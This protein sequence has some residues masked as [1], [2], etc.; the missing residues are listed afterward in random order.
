MENTAVHRNKHIKKD[1][2]SKLFEAGAIVIILLIAVFSIIPFL[3]ILSGSFSKESEIIVKG[4]SLLPQGFTLDSYKMVFNLGNRISQAYFITIVTTVAGTALGLLTT[5]M[6]GYVLSR[7]DFKHRNKAAFFIYFTTL[8]S[9]GMIASYMVNVNI[10]HLNNN[11]WVMILPSIMSPFNI[12]LFRNFVK[13][14]P[15]SLVE[16]ARIDGAGDFRVFLQ[17]I[18]PLSK[19]AFATI[20]LFLALGYWNQWFLC[21]LYIKDK[22][23]YTLQYLLYS[24][25]ANMD[26]MLRDRSLMEG[27][28]QQI[29][30]ETMKLATAMLATAP[31]LLFYPFVQKYFVGGL[32]IGGVK[33]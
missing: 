6:S 11:I 22:N 15:D 12:F 20:G 24:M 14:I 9:G 21:N 1:L 33:G 2:A 27:S 30:T 29:P 7:R 31:V 18:I 4:Y 3:F 25:L 32:T 28:V 10:L 13:S 5:S 8:F 16:S 26:A 23:L 17:I 19:P